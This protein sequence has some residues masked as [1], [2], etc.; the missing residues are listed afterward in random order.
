MRDIAEV[1]ARL[2]AL[3]SSLG[4]RFAKLEYGQREVVRVVQ[5]ASRYNEQ[6]ATLFGRLR[7]DA[8][9][10]LPHRKLLDVLA[11][12]YDDTRGCFVPVSFCVLVRRARVG[13][14]AASAYL[15]LLVSKGY[16]QAT[17]DGYRKYFACVDVTTRH[18]ENFI[19][20]PPQG[21]GWKR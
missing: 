17:S 18:P 15:R 6:A 1:L 7:G 12:S 5:G 10:R 8:D 14:G 13:K 4:V 21:V 19:C 16:V 11:A 20:A 2:G 9:V 3:E